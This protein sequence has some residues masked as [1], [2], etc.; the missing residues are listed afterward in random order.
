MPVTYVWDVQKIESYPTTQNQAGVTTTVHWTASATDGTRTTQSYGSAIVTPQVNTG[1]FTAFDSLTKSQV[2]G[3]VYT[4]LG[5]EKTD[6]EASMAS[7]I[8]FL[9]N[10]PAVRNGLPAW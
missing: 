3:W 7:R 5:S 8:A 2:L 9:A 4:V 6:V 10:P 1:Q